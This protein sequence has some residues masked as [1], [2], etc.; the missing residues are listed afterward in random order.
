MSD[1]ETRTLISWGRIARSQSRIYRPLGTVELQ[2]ILLS[3]NCV[4]RGGGMSYGDAALSAAGVVIETSDL[5]GGKTEFD[6]RCGRLY[7]ASGVTQ[8]EVLR[9]LSPQGWVLPSMPGSRKIT[10]G[11]MIAA[12]AH[13]KDH[14]R[15]GS[16]SRHLISMRIMLADGEIVTCSRE[17]NS[18]LFWST[19]GGL[20]L[21]GVILDAEIALKKVDSVYAK[22]IIVGFKGVDNLIEIIENNT[23]KFEY[24]LGWVNGNFRPG[25]PW[26]GG[27]SLG[28]GLNQSEIEKPWSLPRRRI[29]RLPFQNPLPGGA[30]LTSWGLNY[31]LDK[32]FSDGNSEVVDFDRFFFP[33]DVF[34]NWNISFGNAGFVDYQFCV[35][36]Q[37][38]R[39]AFKTIEAFMSERKVSCFLIAVKRF[40]MPERRGPFSFVQEGYSMALDIPMRTN[41]FDILDELDQIVASYSGRVNPIKDSRIS[42]AMLRRMYPALEEWLANRRIFDPHGTFCSDMSNRLELNS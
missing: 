14:Y 38:A 6:S 17:I 19:I 29:F 22:S 37:N 7:C 39:E 28:K 3:E 20:G 27:V 2:K 41:L 8:G 12:D 35:S 21:T 30:K 11:G 42:P 40:G 15:N 26:R 33:Q 16:I 5:F 24:I 1:K 25:Q 34:S 9:I 4:P 23:N 10:I 18:E 13:G 32:K 31:A 36:S